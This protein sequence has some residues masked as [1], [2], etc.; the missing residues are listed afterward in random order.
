L[1]PGSSP[2]SNLSNTVPV[3]QAEIV[4]ELTRGEEPIG[5]AATLLTVTS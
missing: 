1:N 3:L 5:H 4:G 2:R